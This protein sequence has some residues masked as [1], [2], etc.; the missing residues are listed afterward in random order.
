L[1]VYPAVAMRNCRHM[2][3]QAMP[4]PVTAHI[5]WTIEHAPNAADQVAAVPLVLSAPAAVVEAVEPAPDASVQPDL[6]GLTAGD[7]E[8]FECMAMAKRASAID[9][10][11]PSWAARVNA[12]ASGLEALAASLRDPVARGLPHLQQ[13]QGGETAPPENGDHSWR[14]REL[15]RVVAAPS[16]VLA[17]DASLD[18]LRLAQNADVLNMAVEL[19]QDVGAANG[20]EQMLAHQLAAAHQV[21]MNLFTAAARDLHRH[22]TAPSLNTG[23]LLDA[24]RSAAVGARVM[25][26]FAQGMAVLDRLRNGNRQVVVVQHTTVNEGGQA[27]V[28]GNVAPGGASAVP[29]VSRRGGRRK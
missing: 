19:A 6:A 2:P 18:R 16:P 20:G 8:M 12:E 11:D 13:G 5:N 9:G 3:S 26:S 24:Q 7:A 28:A 23:A 14:A 15:E 10:A 22:Q 27:V 4:E 17:A 29:A 1:A 21:G 25:S